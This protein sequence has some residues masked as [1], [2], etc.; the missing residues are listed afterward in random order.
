MTAM[1]NVVDI[2]DH[3]AGEHKIR[4]YCDDHIVDA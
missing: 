1:T 3:I 2:A 4:P